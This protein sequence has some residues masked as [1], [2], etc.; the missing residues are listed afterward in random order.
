MDSRKPSILRF[1]DSVLRF[2][3]SGVDTVNIPPMKGRDNKDKNDSGQ[4]TVYIPPDQRCP[5]GWTMV[6][7]LEFNQGRT[8]VKRVKEKTVETGEGLRLPAH[9]Q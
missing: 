5:P 9:V 6:E 8:L 7:W 1:I 4:D 2:I 3:D